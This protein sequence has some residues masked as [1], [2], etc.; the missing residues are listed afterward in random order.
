[1]PLKLVVFFS[2]SRSDQR[3]HSWKFHCAY[4]AMT[5]LDCVRVVG[6]CE[7]RECIH[8]CRECSLK[9]MAFECRATA[10]ILTAI[11]G[12]CVEKTTLANKC[13]TFNWELVHYVHEHE[14]HLP[15]RSSAFASRCQPT[16]H[17]QCKCGR[18]RER[19]KKCPSNNCVIRTQCIS[20]HGSRIAVVVAAAGNIVEEIFGVCSMSVPCVR[21]ACESIAS[22]GSL[23]LSQRICFVWRK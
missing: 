4:F 20:M 8:F 3:F 15:I 23:P 19:E 17:W 6:M 2:V 13:E 11:N 21:M 18:G 22:F 1:M 12:K 7:S 16:N 10:D 14:F 5:H 9:W